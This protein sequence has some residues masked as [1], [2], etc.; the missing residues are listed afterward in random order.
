MCRVRSDLD[1]VIVRQDTPKVLY[2]KG[3]HL[4]KKFLMLLVGPDSKIL[5]IGQKSCE[6]V[7][8]NL[9]LGQGCFYYEYGCWI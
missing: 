7:Q 8:T 1:W 3:G 5:G 2:P 9:T 4:D 6:N